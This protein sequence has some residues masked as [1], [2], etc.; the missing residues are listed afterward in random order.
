MLFD[1]EM[2]E[3]ATKR[4]TLC[5]ELRQA[6]ERGELVVVYQPIFNLLEVNSS[7]PGYRLTGFEALVRWQSPLRGLLEPDDFISVAEECGADRAI[8]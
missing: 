2:R 6:L 7:A 3:E 4:M 8:G 5:G 1:G